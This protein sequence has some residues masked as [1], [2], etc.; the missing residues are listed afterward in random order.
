M[1]TPQTREVS[2]RRDR[3]P[4]VS[5]LPF[6]LGSWAPLIAGSRC[7]VWWWT[8]AGFLGPSLAMASVMLAAAASSPNGT[9]NHTEAGIAGGLIIAAWFGGICFSFAIR[10]AYD[11]RRGLELPPPQWPRPSGRS[12]QWS[13]RYAVCAYI[14]SFAIVVVFGLLLKDLA[15]VHV[16]VGVGVLFVDLVLL[17]TLV[18]ASRRHGIAAVDLGLRPTLALRSLWLAVQAGVAYIFI[19]AL[20]GVAFIGK[21]ARHDAGLL[22]QVQHLSPLGKAVAVVAV[23][24]SAPVV[25]EIFFRGLLYRSLRNR[26][27]VAQSALLAGALFGLVHITGYPLITLPVKAIFGVIACLLYE[28]TGSLL[29]GIALHSFIDASGMDLALTGNDIIVLGIA[30][31][32]TTLLFARAGLLKATRAAK[33]RRVPSV[34]SP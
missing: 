26:L 34:A 3:W 33:A 24:V 31:C 20:W 30:G 8:L 4:W 15:H 10:P 13:T 2:L 12:R 22:S 32:L 29:P 16:S 7:R 28:R 1:T 6:G 17:T 23:A 25:E 18:P 5:L 21:S 11:R 14:A 19:G 27:P 9:A